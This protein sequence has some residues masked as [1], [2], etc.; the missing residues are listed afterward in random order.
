MDVA[1]MYMA[2]IS[3]KVTNNNENMLLFNG[4]YKIGRELN[5]AVYVN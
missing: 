2:I 1:H 5:T 4:W 3:S